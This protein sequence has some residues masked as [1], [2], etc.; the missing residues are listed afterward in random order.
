ME[1]DYRIQ[2]ARK[3]REHLLDRLTDPRGA[4][5]HPDIKAGLHPEIKAELRRIDAFIQGVYFA[6]GEDVP[7]DLTRRWF[8]VQQ[9]EGEPSKRLWLTE[10]EATDIARTAVY[11]RDSLK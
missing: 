3:M 2:G 10:D 11:V 9:R 8:T 4:E 1:I 6:L 7:D 5:L